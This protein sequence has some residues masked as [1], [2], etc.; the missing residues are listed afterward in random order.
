MRLAWNVHVMTAGFLYNSITK[1]WI[2]RDDDTNGV[3]I[4]GMYSVGNLFYRGRQQGR[5]IYAKNET[6]LKRMAEDWIAAKRAEYGPVFGEIFQDDAW[7]LRIV[8]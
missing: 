6:E 7:E 3:V 4:G 1:G 8:A 2:M 5:Q